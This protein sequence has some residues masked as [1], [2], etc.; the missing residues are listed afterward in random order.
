MDF[1]LKFVLPNVNIATPA[2][3]TVFIC[4]KYPFPYPHFQP[5]YLFCPNVSL[6]NNVL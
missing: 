3:I 5:V 4:M 1:V 2:L 6:V